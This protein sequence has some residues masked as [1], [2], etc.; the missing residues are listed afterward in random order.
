MRN[1]PVSHHLEEHQVKTMTYECPWCGHCEIA[2]HRFEQH[3]EQHSAYDV[4]YFRCGAYLQTGLA[5]FRAL[6]QCPS[7]EYRAG[8]ITM[9]AEHCKLRH[10]SGTSKSK[11]KPKRRCFPLADIHLCEQMERNDDE[12]R[13]VRAELEAAKGELMTRNQQPEVIGVFHGVSLR[14]DLFT[15]RAT[16]YAHVFFE[17]FVPAGDYSLHTGQSNIDV[18]LRMHHSCPVLPILR[19]KTADAENPKAFPLSGMLH[20]ARG[21]PVVWH[22]FSAHKLIEPGEYTLLDA[23]VCVLSRVTVVCDRVL[24]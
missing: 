5:P 18:T 12:I 4:R 3:V 22:V 15:H 11:A 7:C 20:V 13:R 16:A 19:E 6:L 8:S 10:A 9:I 2:K 1:D 21:P 24:A 14:G 23:S 17:R